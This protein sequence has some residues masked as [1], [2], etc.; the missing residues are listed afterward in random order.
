MTMILPT[1]AAYVL[2]IF[3]EQPKAPSGYQ[4]TKFGFEAVARLVQCG[5]EDQT[6]V[7]LGRTIA[8]TNIQTET[9]G[10]EIPYP[11]YFEAT[12]RTYHYVVA[13]WA[14]RTV[15]EVCDRETY[16]LLSAMFPETAEQLSRALETLVSDCS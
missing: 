13:L 4:G 15:I 1:P 5:G 3:E 7:L 12:G 16:Q 9:P 6:M 14:D 10:E 8:A 11:V 2:G